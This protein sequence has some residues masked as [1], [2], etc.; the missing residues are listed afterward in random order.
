MQILSVFI[1]SVQEYSPYDPQIESQRPAAC[2]VCAFL[3]PA[4][5]GTYVRQVWLPHRVWLAVRRFGCR[6]PGCGCTI[7]LLPSFCVPFKRYG[8]ALVE[9]CVDAV[10]RGGQSVRQWS[11]RHGVTDRA[12]GG[13]WLRQFGMVCGLLL[14][15]GAQRLGLRLSGLEGSAAQRAW[16]AL[17]RHSGGSAVLSC[18]QPVLCA[19][20]PPLGLFRLRL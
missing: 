16:G 17:R 7:S 5:K 18:V 3:R 4:G 2:P 20:F 1:G 13:T 9:S 15:T 12:T 14:T 8:S 19:E 6:R 10:L 11:E